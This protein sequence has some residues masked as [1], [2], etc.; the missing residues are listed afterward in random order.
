MTMTIDIDTLVA[1]LQP[2]RPVSPRGGVLIALVA[3]AVVVAIVSAAFGLRADVVA[4]NPHPMVMLREGMLLLLG[5]A[6]LAAVVASAR[7]GVGQSSTGWRWALAGASLFPLT[8]IALAMTTEGFPLDV[9]FS[10][11]GPWCLGIS[12]GG[13]LLIGA[14]L[15]LWLRK[16]APTALNRIG[17]LV[18]LASGSFGAFAYGLHCPSITVFYVGLWYTGAILLCALLGRLIVPRLIRW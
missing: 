8:S 15:T 13:G 18:G 3:A 6:S 12:L 17:W 5:F 16:G 2:V 10:V 4:G 9:L 7:P 1:D 11:D 14:G